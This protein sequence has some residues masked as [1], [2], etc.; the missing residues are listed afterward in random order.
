MRIFNSLT[1]EIEEFKPINDKAVRIYSCGPTVYDHAHIGNL[2][3]YIFADTLRRAI[4]SAGYSVQHV[5]NYTDV[6]DKTIKRSREA[7]SELDP[8]DALTKLT[9]KYKSLFIQD[10]Q[11]LAIDA[12]EFELVS[13][14]ESI[15]EMQELILK[16]IKAKMA[17]ITEDGIYFSIQAYTDSGKTYG[18]LVSVSAESTSEARINN[19]EYEKESAHDFALWKR[20]KPGEPAW[21]FVV[22]GTNI[23]GRPGWHIECSAMTNKTLGIPFD[24]HTGG[25]DLMFPHHENEIAQSTGVSD[26]PVMANY[27][28]HNN[29]VLVDGKKMSKSAQNFY[30]LDD[31]TDKGFDPLAFRLLVLQSHY[32]N[33]TSFTWEA[34]ESAQNRLNNWRQTVDLYWQASSGDADSTTDLKAI[35]QDNLDTPTLVA[36][37]DENITKIQAQGLKAN[38]ATIEM[39]ATNVQD[40]LGIDLLG[41]DISNETK[42][43]IANREKSRATKDWAQADKLRDELLERGIGVR[44][45]DDGTIWYRA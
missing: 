39:L 36:K 14:V 11:E 31:I 40:L 32:R 42:D 27:F 43:L 1:K 7:H 24:I 2:S 41:D 13:A 21:D 28:V 29:H 20:Q 16:L 35:L 9:D 30:T 44:D 5:M 10:I 33:E 45:T 38:R 17:Y 37:I 26:N 34:L 6:D 12:S 15:P 3:A 22:D 23:K 19:D 8:Q 18:Q 25:I 4:L